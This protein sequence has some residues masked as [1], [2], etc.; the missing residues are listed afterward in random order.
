L[1]NA[2]DNGISKFVAGDEDDTSNGS[3]TNGLLARRKETGPFA[4]GS[5]F[6]SR[7]NSPQ[8][9]PTRS[10]S[11]DSTQQGYRAGSPYS[12]RSSQSSVYGTTVATATRRLST[13]TQ[14]S[15]YAARYSVAAS[16]PLVHSTS[17]LTTESSKT[18]T[19]SLTTQPSVPEQTETSDEKA[20]APSWNSPYGYYGGTDTVATNST[21]SFYST[22]IDD[23]N[24]SSAAPTTAGYSTNT[25]YTSIYQT[26]YATPTGPNDDYQQQDSDATTSQTQNKPTFYDTS[27]AS[28]SSWWNGASAPTFSNASNNQGYT[29]SQSYGQNATNNDNRN[30]GADY[31]DDE[32]ED[33][34][35]GNNAL[36]KKA[37]PADADNDETSSSKKEPEKKEEPPAKST[38]TEKKEEKKSGKYE[39]ICN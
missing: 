31:Y 25:S 12:R 37:P 3:G 26:A 24:K 5:Q 1:I 18:Q 21:V 32:E 13:T 30:G 11:V 39:L 17:S 4:I 28:T 2:I 8:T 34:G 9:M 20:A 33:L 22:N 10:T 14:A 6:H 7:P 35:L 15:A 23:Q 38:E 29:S 19:Y 27:S 16:S 36:R